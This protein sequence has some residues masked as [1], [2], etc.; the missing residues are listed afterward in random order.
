MLF[1][2]FWAAT[3]TKEDEWFDEIDNQVFP[4]KTNTKCWLKSSEE[5]NKSKSL[6][7][8]SRSSA[9]NT[10]K[11]PKS[12]RGSKSSKEIGNEDKIRVPELVEEAEL[13]K[14]KQIIECEAQKLKIRE[15]LAKAR[16]RVSTYD[17]AK[18]INFEEAIIHKASR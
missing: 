13:L 8:S 17:E 14:K 4:F 5:N 18:L 11:E 2:T 15:K 16:A 3:V 6:S 12:S 1:V 7:R 9:S 10:P